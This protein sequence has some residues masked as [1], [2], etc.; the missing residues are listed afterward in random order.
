ME[1]PSALLFDGIGLVG[2]ALY[3]GAYAGLQFGFIKGSGYTYTILNMTAAAMVLVSLYN[4]FNLSSAIIQMTWIAISIFGLT[5]HFILHHSTKLT[6]DEATFARSKLPSLS[7]TMVRKLFLAGEWQDLPAGTV[8]VK[9]GEKL[10]A[11]VYLLLGEADVTHEREA[12]GALSSDSFVGELTCFD[13]GCASATVTLRSPARVF[14][15]S[16]K[17]LNGLC[18]RY[19]EL[20]VEVEQA[21]RKDTGAKLMAA[22]S[23]LSQPM[24]MLEA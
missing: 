12:V 10:S 15:I 8:I 4:N 23:R 9:E 20:K 14:R 3:I 13:D 1:I 5:R 19:P 6:A 18:N 11:L 2:V 17:K 24:R 16:S 21:I 7:K 22:N